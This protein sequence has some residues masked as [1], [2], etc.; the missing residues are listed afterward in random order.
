MG[1]P[2]RSGVAIY[3]SKMQGFGRFASRRAGISARVIHSEIKG[4][5]R[6]WLEV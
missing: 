3:W 1:P 6:S 4:T 2:I 5:E